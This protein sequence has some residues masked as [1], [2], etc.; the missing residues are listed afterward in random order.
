MAL[1]AAILVL[2]VLLFLLLDEQTGSNN[3]VLEEASNDL[4]RDQEQSD[5]STTPMVDQPSVDVPANT[6]S[7]RVLRLADGDSFEITWSDGDDAGN[8]DEL[9]LLGINAPELDAC[10]GDAARGVLEVLTLD[11]Q[12]LVELVDR[13]EFGR[14]LANVWADGAFV[15]ARMVELGAALAI[16]DGG[17]HAELLSELQ[18]AAS[19][20]A[21]GLWDPTFCG[22]SEASMLRIAHIESDAP[23]PDNE[24]PNG[25]WIEIVND[26]DVAVELRGWTIRDESTRHRYAFPEAFALGAGA[27]VLVYSGCGADTAAELYWCD[28]DPVWN[29]GGDT[30]F[31]VDPDGSF[32]DTLS[33]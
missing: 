7:A 19:A 13:D 5:E 8:V 31:L 11:R 9:R 32:A 23:G 17:P 4:V 24:N 21:V 1:A 20:A 22:P 30:G 3:L 6:R 2:V 14:G 26:G 27:S 25:E 16:S 18:T 10:F 12:L 33:Y 28:G 15:N 29:N